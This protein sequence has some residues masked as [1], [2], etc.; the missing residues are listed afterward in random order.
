MHSPDLFKKS[1]V[2]ITALAL[3]I[4]VALPLNIITPFTQAFSS[5][6]QSASLAQTSR[7][8]EA[9]RLME[10]ADQLDRAG[11]TQEAIALWQRALPIYQAAG[12]RGR[13][14]QCLGFLGLS[15]HLLGD[16][17]NT[18]RYLEPFIPIVRERQEHAAEAT[19]LTYLGNA[20]FNLQQYGRAV[21]YFEDAI[22]AAQRVQQPGFEHISLAGL[23]LTYSYLGQYGRA[24]ATHQRL[25]TLSQQRRDV[26]HQILARLGLG[27]T[28]DRLGNVPQSRTQHQ[29]AL[30]LAQQNGNT[31]LASRALNGL[32]GNAFELRDYPQAIRHYQDALALAKQQ[33]DREGEANA[34]GNLGNV[35]LVSDDANRALEAYQDSLA[36]AE[37]RGDRQ[38]IMENLGGL[39]SAY[40]LAGN[41]DQALLQYQ[42]M[43]AIARQLNT[44]LNEGTA[45][46]NLGGALT[47]LGRL[48]EGEQ[49]LQTAIRLWE[50]LRQNL[51]DTDR[52]ALFETQQVTYQQLQENLIRQGKPE[53]ALE[54][55]EQG[56]AQAFLA[57][58]LQRQ[59]AA[60]PGIQP[61]A[62]TFAQIQAIARQ[63]NATLVEYSLLPKPG[64]RADILIWVVQPNGA[65]TFRQVETEKPLTE[66]VQVARE[67]IG[68]RFAG[69]VARPDAPAPDPTI[70]A[71]QFKT[72]HQLLIEPIA[73]VLPQDPDAPVILVPHRELFLVPFA[74]LQ[75][76]AGTHLIE[77]HTLLNVPALQMLTMAAPDRRSPTGEAVVVG[78]PIMPTRDTLT[79]ALPQ[80][81]RPLPGAE[82]EARAIAT[83]LGTEPLI[84]RQATETT[85]TQKLSAAPIIHL[86]T[87]GILDDA[88]GLQSAIALTPD[89]Q[90]DGWLTAE[91]LL[92]LNLSAHLAILSA[93]DTGQGR[94]TGDG[95]IGLSRSLVT[96]GIPSVIVSIWAVPDAPT[97]E[98]MTEFYRQLDQTRNKAQAL[99][100]AMLVTRE[101]HPNPRNWAAFV[102]I[103]EAE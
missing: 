50:R 8:A 31:E 75:D 54:A 77:R 92:D 30:Q 13:E 10:Q 23:G 9:D 96:A 6:L 24:I 49:Q 71:E 28:Y 91:E 83:A 11:R 100:R 61:T 94:I 101:N 62:P 40:E 36:I 87:H 3:S 46:N 82:Q 21:A 60:T 86:A 12:S 93:C 68:V 74:A 16:Y 81:L 85:V 67:S 4:S 69:V 56:R 43:V 35:Y 58:L 73:S 29:E 19:G 102:L 33:G 103:G 26:T 66:L 37:S 72:L 65:L 55:A 47:R 44:P 78:N 59:S 89:A 41:A 34:L 64:Q 95:V 20:Y 5:P 51:S 53:A 70:E 38:S 80:P 88:Q 7:I 99:R 90:N 2:E 48:S 98:L 14:A 1:S 27:L 39:G 45:L 79:E 17:Q 84:G 42:R 76:D 25:L 22:P 18:V 57:L 52:V 97:A 32:G 15:Y 63:R